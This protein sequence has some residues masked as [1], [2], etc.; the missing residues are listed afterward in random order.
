[1]AKLSGI[2][3]RRLRTLYDLGDPI[4]ITPIT[5]LIGRNSSGKSTF[6]RILPLLRQSV[7]RKKRSPVLW[8]GDLVDFGTFSQ[9]VT[10]G[11]K[12]IDLSFEVDNIIHPVNKKTLFTTNYNELRNKINLPCA[13]VNLTLSSDQELESTVAKKLTIS[14]DD[15]EIEINFSSKKNIDTIT[16]NNKPY[17]LNK[18]NYKIFVEQ[19]EILPKIKFAE[20]RKIDGNDRWFY[21][22]NPWKN[23]PLGII[24]ERLHQN[25]SNETIEKISKKLLVSTAE[26]TLSSA[27]NINDTGTW[28][29][30]VSNLNKNS[31]FIKRIQESLLISNIDILLEKLDEAIAETA[32][33]IKYIKPL[34]ATAERYYRRVD[35]AVSEID[36]EGRNL[37]IFLDSLT[38]AQLESFQRWLKENLDI[39]VKTNRE[40]SQII[41]LA[42]TSN[43]SGLSNV[44][45]MGFG[46]SQILP[47]AAQ[48]WAS[49]RAN[50]S[51]FSPTSIIVIEQ[52]ELHLHPAL[53]A[54]IGN[55][56]AGAVSLGETISLISKKEPPRIVVETHSQHLINRL[57]LLIEEGK[58]SS[59]DVSIVI[60]EPN[61]SRKG[62][63]SARVSKFNNEGVLQDWPFGFFEPEM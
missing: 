37:P 21:T 47:I 23:N 3:T 29:S 36:P 56:L 63:S 51:A 9:A 33:G 34:R 52:P 19:G 25:T 4:K 24:K 38:T 45:D 53:Q 55:V 17:E 22:E 41:L 7:E 57:G 42:K 8:Y 46:I 20:K 5:V 13:K 27:K 15:I 58:I 60:F 48:I 16:I 6:A 62:T 26:K 30:F 12:T 61:P 59:D 50:E 54:K 40:G 14:I 49:N 32:R 2:G 31:S 11:E 18:E 10:R 1:M 39:E 35:L 28:R 43:D 44:A